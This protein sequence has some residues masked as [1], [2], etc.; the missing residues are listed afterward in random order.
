MNIGIICTWPWG[1]KNAESEV[2]LR[3]Q[4]ACNNIGANLFCITKEGF[5]V[6][7]N[8]SKTTQKFDV[9][10][11]DFLITMHYEDFKML[12]CFTYHALWNPPKI[13]LQYSL[14]PLYMKN[15]AT[16][17]D[18]LIYDKGGMSNHLKSILIDN[19]RNLD[20]ASSLTASFSYTDAIEPELP[21][22]IKLFYC[23]VNWERYI[24]NAESRHTGLFKLLDE[25]DNVN[26]YGPEHS[27][28]GYN[29]YKG[30]IPFDGT[31][32]LKEIHKCG[33]GLA[34]SSDYHYRAGAATNRI[35]E[36]S[37]AGCITISDTNSFIM[38][39]FGD[40]VLYI[41]YDK[42][43]YK[44]MYEQINNHL[45]WIKNNPEAALEKAKKAQEIFKTKFSLEKQLTE[46]YI[47]I[48]TS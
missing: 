41:D 48:V 2:I 39:N 46:N 17:D 29:N 18:F 28:D 15:I 44:K 1:V 42:K 45:S 34:L 27:W 31:T 7:E 10:T 24:K 32:I 20:G 25:Q 11:L 9:N 5:I 6:D 26:L 4:T 37:A 14:Y 40:S 38:E 13:T 16:N 30:S 47:N 19:P 21:K 35:Y 12:D 3:M 22:D 33:V 43:D 8:F 36:I 23:G